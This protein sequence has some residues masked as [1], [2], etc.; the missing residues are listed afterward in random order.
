M[1][2]SCFTVCE[3]IKVTSPNSRI[4][5]RKL[6]RGFGHRWRYMVVNRYSTRQ[7]TYLVSVATLCHT[8]RAQRISSLTLISLNPYL[9]RTLSFQFRLGFQYLKACKFDWR[10]VH[11][12]LFTLLHFRYKK[13]SGVT[14]AVFH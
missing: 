1:F 7:C 11:K 8:T 5:R 14:C 6:F 2:L 12:S 3:Y 9:P 10:D 4:V 13:P